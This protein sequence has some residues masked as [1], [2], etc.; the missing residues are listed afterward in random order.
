MDFSLIFKRRRLLFVA[1][2][3]GLLAAACSRRVGTSWPG[4][5]VVG[6]QQQIAVAFQNRVALVDPATGQAVQLV[7]SDGDVR[8]DAEGN[9]RIWQINGSENNGAQFFTPPIVADDE[10][11]YLASFNAG[12]FEVDLPTGRINNPSGV[13]LGQ[14]VVANLLTTSDLIYVGYV[15]KN[16][17]ALNREDFSVRWTFET[18]H[19]VWSAPL[20]VDGVLY[21]PSL[22]HNLYAADAATGEELW[23]VDLGGAVTSAPVYA[24][25]HLYIGSFARKIFDIS[26]QSG[27]ILSEYATEDWVWASP[28]LVDDV[29]Y[30]PDL[31][32][33]V[34][35]L[36]IADG[37]SQR[38]KALIATDAI[39]PSAVVFDDTIVVASRDHNIY[40]ISRE[41]GEPLFNRVLSDEALSDLHVIAAD[42]DAGIDEDLLIVGT[43]SGDERLVAFTLDNGERVWTYSGP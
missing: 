9:P 4:V 13:E 42:E 1:L 5:G 27:E 11:L 41:T 30:V 40:W 24:D 25:G 31:A 22:D 26:A 8:L 7:D 2:I 39:R 28:T 16:F 23:R 37:L 3:F 36:E 19:G 35:A 33:Y 18:E 14:Q 6:D 29:L 20:L 12:M 34:Y 15:D 43:M 21:I 17:A 10:T 38:W 32:G